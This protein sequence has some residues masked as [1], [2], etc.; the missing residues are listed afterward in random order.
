MS[1]EN[2]RTNNP[3][4]LR[5]TSRKLAVLLVPALL[6]GLVGSMVAVAGPA[7]AALP[8]LVHVYKSFVGSDDWQR[9]TATCPPNKV[10]VGT[11]AQVSGGGSA[12]VINSI[13]PNGGTVTAPT[14]VTVVAWEADPPYAPAWTTAHA[15]C[16]NPIPGLMRVFEWQTGSGDFQDA[17]AMCPSGKSLLGTGADL[18]GAYGEVTVEAIMPNGGPATAP[19]SVFVRAYESDPP[20]F[21]DWTVIAY[22]ICANTSAVPGLMRVAQSSAYNSDSPKIAHATC[23]AGKLL[24]GTGAL[25]KGEGEV[26]LHA[27]RPAGP[28]TTELNRNTVSAYEED[29]YSNNWPMQAFA[30]C[31]NR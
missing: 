24:T 9:V 13:R 23:P 22:A 8:G 6:T 18:I 5:G 16:A 26:V 12:I 27:L 25:A 15:I 3:R 1:T 4:A 14:A 31:A 29:P 17:T 2:G 11:G 28:S 30:I 7:S 10:L 20:Y 21:S 19:T